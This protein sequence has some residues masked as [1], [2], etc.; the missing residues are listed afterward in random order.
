MAD[1]DWDLMCKED[2]AYDAAVEFYMSTGTYGFT[3][4]KARRCISTNRKPQHRSSCYD[5][6]IAAHPQQ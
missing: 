1:E 2:Q 6:Y 4:S 5:H 3:D